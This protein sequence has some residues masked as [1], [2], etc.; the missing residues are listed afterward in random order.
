M[1][2]FVVKALEEKRAAVWK[3]VLGT[4]ELPIVSPVPQYAM[5]PEL[6]VVEVYHVDLG[7]LSDEIRGKMIR[8]IATRFGFEVA[9]VADVIDCHGVPLPVAGLTVY[10]ERLGDKA[11]HGRASAEGDGVTK[12]SAEC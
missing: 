2:K 1:Y 3:D 5:L 7:A 10:V 8:H 9:A 12:T 6:G 4:N 11:E